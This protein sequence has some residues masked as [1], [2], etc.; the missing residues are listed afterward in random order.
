[1]LRRS[2]WIGWDSREADAFAVAR[3][4][5]RRHMSLPLPIR[6][7]V[8]SDL[9][10]RGLYTRPIEYRAS[11]VDR[12]IMWD[13]ISDAP[14]STEH[15]CSRFLI[16]EL[17]QTGW[18]LFTD[19]DI[20]CRSNICRAFDALDNRYAAYCVKHHYQA[21]PGRKMDGMVQTAYAKKNWSSVMFLNADHPSNKKLTPE[22]INTIPGRD[23]HAFCWLDPDEIGALDPGWNFLIGE[24]RPIDDVKI[25][26]F[27]LG[28]PSML[29]YEQCEFSDEWREELLTWAR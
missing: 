5:M 23:L 11:A 9:Q 14:M 15:A 18:A 4:S 21:T 22:L 19:G 3:V 20:L 29:G 6:G 25:A 1:M 12:P 24:S 10:K 28:T 8:L 2:I 27:T 17:A 7:V 16:K 26:H 13:V